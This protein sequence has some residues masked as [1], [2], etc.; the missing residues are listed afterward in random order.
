MP[1]NTSATTHARTVPPV[2]IVTLPT[3]GVAGTQRFL[4]C[5]PQSPMSGSASATR[6]LKSPTRTAVR[7][8]QGE[9]R[10]EHEPRGFCARN[11]PLALRCSRA[12]PRPFPPPERG[13]PRERWPLGQGGVS[14]AATSLPLYRRKSLQAGREEIPFRVSSLHKA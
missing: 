10:A 13:W 4:S 3:A 12:A 8:T 5:T 14:P 11:S 1:L 2:A 7:E 6:Q 9:R